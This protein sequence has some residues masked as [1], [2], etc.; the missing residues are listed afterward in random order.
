M[1]KTKINKAAIYAMAFF[2]L[3]VALCSCGKQADN[4]ADAN[5]VAVVETEINSA[6]TAIEKGDTSVY[7]A[8]I[9]LQQLVDKK[10]LVLDVEAE[11]SEMFWGKKTHDI[12]ISKLYPDD[13][14]VLLKSYLDKP[15][16]A[17]TE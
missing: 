3:T 13:T 17:L 12:K 1:I 16:T 14:Y 5:N 11:K 9:T 15:I 7:P 4:G 2:M 10:G 6:I 8:D